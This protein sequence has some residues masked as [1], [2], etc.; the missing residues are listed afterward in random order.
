MPFSVDERE[1]IKQHLDNG[2]QIASSNDKEEILDALHDFTVSELYDNEL[3]PTQAC[4]EAEEIIEH[5][6]RYW[7]E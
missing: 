5:V 7:E 2:D 6:A 1:W 3:S 4:R